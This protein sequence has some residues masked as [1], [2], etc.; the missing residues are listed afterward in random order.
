MTRDD[1][2]ALFEPTTERVA[3]E[4]IS[5]SSTSIDP[6]VLLAR[7]SEDVV[8]GGKAYRAAGI[9]VTKPPKGEETRT[10]SLRISG[11]NQDH[12]RMVQELRPGE[13]VTITSMIVFSD[14]QTEVLDGPLSYTAKEV[15]I[16]S[17]TGEISIELEAAQELLYFASRHKYSQEGFRGIWV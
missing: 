1:R 13:E 15:T 12:I 4:L 6:P 5:I 17:V 10:A 9:S 16:E 11:V 2:K 3:V 8:H 14:E 7:N